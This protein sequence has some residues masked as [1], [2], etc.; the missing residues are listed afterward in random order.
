MQ[1]KSA[2]R[3]ANVGPA[4]VGAPNQRRLHDNMFTLASSN[5]CFFSVAY[6]ITASS[7]MYINGAVAAR[8]AWPIVW[9]LLPSVG[10]QL[11]TELQK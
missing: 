1:G 4:N 7:S 2:K 6:Y 10:L 8:P 5:E 3:P 9:L 11:I